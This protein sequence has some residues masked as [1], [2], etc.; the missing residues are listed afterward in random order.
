[1][2]FVEKGC[3]LACSSFFR[4][5]LSCRYERGEVQCKCSMVYYGQPNAAFSRKN[6]GST[7]SFSFILNISSRPCCISF[8]A[9]HIKSRITFPSRLRR[10]FAGLFCS[11]ELWPSSLRALYA[12]IAAASAILFT[13]SFPDGRRHLIWGQAEEHSFS[14]KA[15]ALYWRCPLSTRY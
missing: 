4:A 12:F 6:T 14:G 5:D 9:T 11:T 7:G 1:M 10:R 2:N 15:P 13:A 3:A 8:P